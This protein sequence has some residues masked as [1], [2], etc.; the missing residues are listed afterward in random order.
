[1]VDEIQVA[2][3]KERS[4]QGQER[5]GLRGRQDDGS[6]R[7]GDNSPDTER[8]IRAGIRGGVPRKY[9]EMMRSPEKRD[10]RGYIIPADQPDFLT[11]T[12]FVNALIKTGITIHRASSEFEIKGKK[13]PS[14]SFVVKTAQAFRP[15]V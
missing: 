6:P 7:A 1:D 10:P 3:N 5:G 9:Y 13:Y 2:Y 14:G 11:A 12:K 15:H 4:P 8:L